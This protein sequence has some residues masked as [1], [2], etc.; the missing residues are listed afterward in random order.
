[1]KTDKYYDDK[2]AVEVF[3]K[4]LE[5]GYDGRIFNVYPNGTIGRW[6]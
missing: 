5:E 1:M 4:R 2:E 6:N 3:I